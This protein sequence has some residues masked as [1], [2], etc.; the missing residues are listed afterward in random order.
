MVFACSCRSP[1]LRY[2]ALE[3]RHVPL[4]IGIS[5]WGDMRQRDFIKVIAGSTA[6]AAFVLLVSLI[7]DQR[8]AIALP[9]YAQKEGK[10]CEYC[11]LNP[12]GG[13]ARNAMG[14]QY[15]ENGHKFKK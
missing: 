14:R 3:M 7:V 9:T 12:E 6:L 11:H 13:G 2:F 5:C 15:E 4:V 10:P 8:A 1:Q